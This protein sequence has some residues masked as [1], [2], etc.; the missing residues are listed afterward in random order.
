MGCEHS[1]IHILD[2]AVFDNKEKSGRR[3]QKLFM[4]LYGRMLHLATE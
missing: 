2:S 3:C 4:E 1:S